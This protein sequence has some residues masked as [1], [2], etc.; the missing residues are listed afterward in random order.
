MRKHVFHLLPVLVMVQG[1]YA[2]VFGAPP[3]EIITDDSAEIGSGDF[4]FYY[5]GDPVWQW[6]IPN[7]GYTGVD[8][9]P[10]D[11][12]GDTWPNSYEVVYVDSLWGYDPDG[13]Y[14]TTLYICPDDGGMPDFDHPRY[15]YGPYIPDYYAAWDSR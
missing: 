10:T 4:H 1:S 11:N 3:T 8:F 2:A 7:G 9:D 14:E 5:Y 13:D 12:L 15:T 6:T